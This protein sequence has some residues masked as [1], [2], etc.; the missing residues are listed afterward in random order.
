MYATQLIHPPLPTPPPVERMSSF[1]CIFSTN[2]FIF[3][4][5]QFST[6]PYA[7]IKIASVFI[8]FVLLN[9]FSERILTREVE[10]PSSSPSAAS[11]VVVVILVHAI[12]SK[13]Y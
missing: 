9:S 11:V 8:A 2:Y 5:F 1:L 6:F 13:E 12:D 4:Y 3:S 10:I 7:D